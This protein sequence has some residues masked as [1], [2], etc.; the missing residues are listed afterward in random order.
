M[1]QEDG[2]FLLLQPPERTER[3]RER[4][5]ERERESHVLQLETGTELRISW[6]L[7]KDGALFVDLDDLLSVLPGVLL[8]DGAAELPVDHLH[9]V[10]DAQ[11]GQ[12]QLEQPRVVGGRVVGVHGL[13]TA[14]HD[15]ALVAALLSR[16]D[17]DLS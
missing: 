11:D 16:G 2:L 12:A 1:G 8:D 14:G 7:L 15:D 10:A 17:K 9:P 3:R 4:E 13:G 6:D 5:R